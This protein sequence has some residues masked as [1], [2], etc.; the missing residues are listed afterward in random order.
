MLSPKKTTRSPSRSAKA[1]CAGAAQAVASSTATVQNK[2]FR[3][4]MADSISPCRINFSRIKEPVPPVRNP[5]AK[6]FLMTARIL[7]AL[8]FSLALSAANAQTTPPAPAPTPTPAAG[9][10]AKPSVRETPP[11]QK[12]YTR[13]EE[14]TS[15]LQSLRHLV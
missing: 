6:K 7:T 12:A 1:S 11:D 2:L 13:S 10:A 14:H 8:C 4:G 15:E 5:A 3:W 9:D